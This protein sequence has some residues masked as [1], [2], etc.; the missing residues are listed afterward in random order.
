M[1]LNGFNYDL[2]AQ[3]SYL[4]VELYYFNASCAV[5]SQ[6]SEA[7]CMRGLVS[8]QLTPIQTLFS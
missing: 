7:A 6:A 5:D 8:A 4:N 1:H 3:L 2:N